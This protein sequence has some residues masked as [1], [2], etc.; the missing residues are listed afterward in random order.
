MSDQEGAPGT[1]APSQ[2]NSFHLHAV[3]GINYVTKIR[4]CQK[5]Q[6]MHEIEKNLG[7]SWGRG[8]G[9]PPSRFANVNC[10]KAG[11]PLLQTL[12]C[13]YLPQLSQ[14]YRIQ[15][16]LLFF[17]DYINIVQLSLAYPI[18][19]TP[20]SSRSRGGRGGQVIK[21]MA[22][23]FGCI[24]FMFRTPPQPATGSAIAITQK[25]LA[26]CMLVPSSA[27]LRPIL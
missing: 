13:D 23:E 11:R 22:I 12:S 5:F 10:L 25:L 4:F 7:C 3:F 14:S 26:N 17:V 1:F 15:F 21:K 24:D 20:F 2:S 18:G 19:C 6:K 9:S 27:G 16:F 8:G